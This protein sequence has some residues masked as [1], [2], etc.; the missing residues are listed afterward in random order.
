MRSPRT[1]SLLL[2]VCASVASASQTVRYSVDQRGDFLLIGNTNSYDCGNSPVTPVVGTVGACGTNTGD[3]A[4]DVLWRADA[5]ATGQAQANNAITLAQ[6]R[7]TAM[8]ALPAGATVTYARLYWAAKGTSDAQVTV[9]RQGGFSATVT[10]DVLYPAVNASYQSSA[11]VTALVQTNGPGAYR[12]SGIDSLNPVNLN[13]QTFFTSWSM[14]I[15]Y[16]LDS[17]PPRNLTLFDGF[18]L[19]NTTQSANVTL[20]GFV[21]PDAGFDGKLGIIA[22]EGDLSLTGESF[23][24]NG[25]AASNAL[26]PADNALNGTRSTL[27]VA[28]SNVGDLPQL[29]GGVGSVT[30][31]DLDVFDV[32]GQLA[33]NQTSAP[34][35][36]TS[37][38][39]VFIHGAFITSV[40]TLKPM[41]VDVTK[42]V[43]D[44][45][46]GS[47]VPGDVLEYRITGSNSGTDTARDVVLTDALPTGLTFAPGTITLVSGGVTGA[48][49]DATGDDQGDW[50]AATRTVTVRLGSGATATAGGAIA[51]G[52]SFEVRFRVTVDATAAGT[53][54]NQANLSV[55]GVVGASLGLTSPI[56]Y[57]SDTSGAG[58]RRPTDVT[59]IN[60]TAI[61]SGPALLTNANTAT[62][63][64]STNVAGATFECSLDGA[65]F[66]ACSDPA[67]F[68]GLS[69]GS[70]TL[71]VRY[72]LGAAFD[73]TPAAYTWV[74]D[75][76]A[77]PAP[78]VTTPANGSITT[79]VRPP[80]T[81][82]AEAGSTVTV[83]VDG[84]AV[85]TTTAN[86]AGAWSLTPPA[87]LSNGTHTVR[88]TATDGAGNV[89]P[90]S[91][92][93]TFT[94]DTTAPDTL[95]VAGPPALSSSTSAT[96]DFSASEAVLRFECSVDGGAFAVCADPSTLTGLSQG[97]HT[98]AVRAVDLAGNVDPTPAS[99]SWSVDSIAP[100]APVVV[101]PANGSSTNDTTP[102]FAGTA[103]PN[104][105]VSVIVDGVIVGT[106]TANAA[107]AWSFTPATPLATGSHT[108]RATATDAAG[109]T[110]PSSGTNSFTIDVTPPAAPV[111][112][113]PANGSSTN[114]TTPTYSGT[115]EANATVSVI[116]DGVAIGTTTASA[117]GAWT[118]TPTA[119]L[120]AGPH[121]VRATATDAA[122]NTSVSSATNT[123]TVDVT[124]PAAPVVT[125]PANGSSTNDTTPTYAGTAEANATVTVIVDGV[126]VGTTT[127]NA[128]GA[129]SLTPTTALAAGAHTVRATAT[130]AAGNVSPSSAT[131][132][133]TVD[134]T[135]PVAPVVT[136]PANGTA[137]N[138]ATPTYTGTAEANATVT[139][140]VDGV[141]VGTT[142]A[143]AAGAWSL[144]PTTPLAAGSHTV[145]ARATDAAGNTS[146]DS[147]TNAFTVDVTPPSAPVVTAPA[148]GS[149]TNDDTPTVT[150]TAEPGATVTVIIDGVA[151]GTTTASGSGAWSFT[152]GTALAGGSHT[153][154]ATATDA[155]GNTSPTSNTNTFTVDATAPETTIASGPT[156]TVSSTTASFTF[157]SD[158]PAATFECSL[159]GAAYA[160]CPASHSLS[161]LADG[162]HTLSVRARDGA[163]NV[164]PTP[165]TRTWTVDAT[166]PDTTITMGP[167]GTT[168]ATTATLVF[169]STEANSTFECSLDGAPFTACSAPLALTGLAQGPHTFAVRAIDALGNVDAT[170]ATV[171]WTV[172]SDTDGDG[173]TDD[174]ELSRG[175]D[176]NNPDTDGDGLTDGQEVTAG[177]DPLDADSDDDGVRD[178]QD[179]V[180][181]TDGDGRIDALD[182][183]SDGDGVNDGTERGVTVATAP[184]GTNT[185]SP[186]FVP[187]ADPSTTTDPKVADTDGDGLPDGIED[188][189]H[190]GR[191]GP[192]ETDPNDAD[193]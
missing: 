91:N 139:V 46:G 54:S 115:A 118:F 68:T 51:V 65:A 44:L 103:E 109:N 154:R 183:D 49:T 126:T 10:A 134:V 156:G 160:A 43:V 114:D 87:D 74:V 25:V 108:V 107:G 27:G 67:T 155:A 150:G 90:N 29:T 64:L 169:T 178:G 130:D 102:T 33:P 171:T 45:N 192:S 177:T 17:M 19:V 86:A 97:S 28:V 116:V 5:P 78:S 129:W 32:T 172:R 23:T 79:N 131:N 8:L 4:G 76:T 60:D 140:I 121:T 92:T 135:A 59:V 113:A 175:T 143:N 179:G 88:A 147:N 37:A 72:R 168:G 98:L 162:S 138:D 153:V 31:F 30:G 95:I 15:F 187:D 2:V 99:W 180:T 69:E 6:A 159:D 191:V 47:V 34:L 39:D 173:L 35:A 170:P 77:P 100:A 36:A 80:V 38:G 52:G 193:S 145:R 123:F 56:V 82:T 21:V 101:A 55:L 151:V 164:D 111:V 184:Q 186:N 71:Q 166:A 48:K 119:P 22:Y 112:L 3:T 157:T 167:S 182:P 24:F 141:A 12:V 185:S 41:F 81:G 190:D 137:T 75:R 128:S 132:A 66:A 85:G 26:N 161:G 16:R 58:L 144:T 149:L 189:N 106:T 163:G 9:D 62:F 105:T 40:S 174:D 188:G 176:P 7:T 50:T 181:D 142:T 152:P 14:V 70:H 53:V 18:D 63:D 96:F 93:N 110:S 125:T 94:V 61:V 11:D 120:A 20:S 133:F 148:N 42:T 124:A 73:P 83:F 158:D 127:A 84:V 104:A 136:T 13:D 89:S 117:T 146:P 57:Q 1:F 165:A 122:G